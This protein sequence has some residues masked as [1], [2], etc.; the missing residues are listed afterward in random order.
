MAA[1]TF[2]VTRDDVEKVFEGSIVNPNPVM[3]VLSIGLTPISPTTEVVPVVETPVF[4]RITK[5]PAV[6]SAT[7]ARPATGT[8]VAVGVAVGVAAGAGVVVGVAAGTGVAVEVATGTTVAVGV[9]A[10]AGVVVGV[11]AG[12]V[13]AVGVAAGTVVAVGVAAGAVVALGVAAGAVVAVGVAA[14]GIVVTVDVASGTVVAA[15]DWVSAGVGAGLEHATAD[16]ERIS[17]VT[18]TQ[19]IVALLFVLVIMDPSLNT[20]FPSH[21]SSMHLVFRGQKPLRMVL[22]YSVSAVSLISWA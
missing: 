13:V 7:G 4:V 22:D 9:A 19:R 2:P 5:L 1:Y 11:A 17:A 21:V 20:G 3:A 15:G 16:R 14:A 8:V 10:G 12:T 18:T 6:P